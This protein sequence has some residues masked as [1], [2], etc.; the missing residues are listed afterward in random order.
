MEQLMICR[1]VFPDTVYQVGSAFSVD[2]KIYSRQTC[3]V[4][5]YRLH[6]PYERTV[7]PYLRSWNRMANGLS[8]PERLN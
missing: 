6:F 2:S 1:H 5:L 7:N 8:Y 4:V 3:R